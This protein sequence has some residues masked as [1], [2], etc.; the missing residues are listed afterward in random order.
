MPVAEDLGVGELA[1]AAADLRL[2]ALDEAVPAG[3]RTPFRWRPASR[4]REAPY[5]H[6]RSTER[7]SAGNESSSALAPV[8]CAPALAFGDRYGKC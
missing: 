1:S 6:A 8:G 7:A 2:V 5:G 4:Y 3:T